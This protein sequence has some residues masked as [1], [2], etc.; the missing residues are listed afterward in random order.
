[1]K[2]FSQIFFSYHRKRCARRGKGKGGILTMEGGEVGDEL[3]KR[4]SCWSFECKDKP[5]SNQL[6]GLNEEVVVEVCC[7]LKMFEGG[8]G[9]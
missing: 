4:E 8:R 5:K 7:G 1:M 6:T 9:S 3:F 2:R